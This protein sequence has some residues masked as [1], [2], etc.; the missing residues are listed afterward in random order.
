MKKTF[1]LLFSASIL[2]SFTTKAQ[3]LSSPA[4]GG[5]ETNSMIT[6]MLG[7]EWG[8]SIVVTDLK[9][10]PVSG[11]KVNL[12]CSGAP[13]EF[14][15]AKGTALFQ[16]AGSCPCT[17]SAANVSTSKSNVNQYVSCGTNNVTLPQ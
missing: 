14:T 16:G 17:S 13:Y 9:G 12:P 8:V 5:V 10:N 7:G 6:P 4:S 15:D 3:S 11:A 2:F 1:F